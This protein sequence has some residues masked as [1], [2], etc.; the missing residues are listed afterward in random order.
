[1]L[2]HSHALVRNFSADTSMWAT[3]TNALVPSIRVG[4]VTH[5][6]VDIPDHVRHPVCYDRQVEAEVVLCCSAHI[7]QGGVEV[8]PEGCVKLKPNGRHTDG[9]HHMCIP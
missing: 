9:I 5:V 4:A 7:L 6:K 8:F 2:S 3:K 1:M